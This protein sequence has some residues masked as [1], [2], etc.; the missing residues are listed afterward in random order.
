MTDHQSDCEVDRRLE[1]GIL[2][3]LAQRAP[4]A[5]ICPS[6]VARLV[7]SEDGWRH[8]MDR[9]RQAAR[10]LAASGDVEVTQGGEVVDP[11]VARGPVRIRR[12]GS[13]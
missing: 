6:E 7:G 1:K 3:L 2:D 10:R 12:A 4:G 8:L 9:S 13:P 5:T 11:A